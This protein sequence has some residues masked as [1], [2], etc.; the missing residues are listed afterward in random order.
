MYTFYSEKKI[1]LSIPCLRSLIDVVDYSKKNA[2]IL[3]SL[4]ACH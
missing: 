3:F 4:N 2:N 1:I